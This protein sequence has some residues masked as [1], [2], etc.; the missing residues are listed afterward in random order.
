PLP[1]DPAEPR[2][3]LLA[4]EGEHFEG[5]EAFAG[6]AA[7]QV[8]SGGLPGV[9]LIPRRDDGTFDTLA[10]R[11]LSHGGELE[12]VRLDANPDWDQ[13]VVR[14]R[15]SEEHTSELQSRFELV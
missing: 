1:G 15:R 10:T 13:D 8:R 12:A 11:T 7:L 5:I 9:R 4:R 3:L 14:Y 2:P 6:F